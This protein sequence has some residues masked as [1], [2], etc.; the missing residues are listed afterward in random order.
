MARGRGGPTIT[1]VAE[2]AGV[3]RATVS[4]VLN[5]HP[6]VDPGIGARV[7]EAA[8]RLQYR[9]NVTAR[10]LSTGRTRT[11]ALII[12]D[13]GNP[14]FQSLL[15]G[16]SRAAEADGYSVL[17]AEAGSPDTEA[18]LARDARR[19]CDAIMLVSPRMDDLSLEEVLDQAG[20]VV[21][22]NRRPLNPR[23]GVVAI[24]YASGMHQLVEH[25]RELGH[26]D[27]VY[28][29][30]PPRSAA[31]R[32]RLA[33][34][35]SLTGA[36]PSLTLQVLPGGATMSA[37]YEAAE[38]VLAS[39]ATAA[40]AFNDL[41]A[42]GLQSRLNEFGVNVP[43]DISV[44]GFDGIELSRFAVPRLTS[45]GQEQLDAGSVA[46]S[47][48]HQR[49]DDAEGKAGS[50]VTVLEP[51]LQVGDST[52]RVPPSRVPTA[53]GRDGSEDPRAEDLATL[54]FGW[55]REGRDWTLLAGGTL[56]AAAAS[57]SSMPPVHSPRPHLHPVRSLGGRAMTVTNP[58][59]HRHHFGLSLTVPDVNG[60]TYWGG[61]TYVEG[62]GSTLLANHGVQESLEETPD[63]SGH[64]L[65]SRVQWRS[66]DGSD[67]L[68]E[69]RRLG[70][71]LLPGPHGW[72][73]RW[74]SRLR[75]SADPVT[76]TSPANRGR[77]GA[78]YGGLFW[79]LP[80]ADEVRVLVEGGRGEAVAHGSRS[81]FV[82][83]Q[84][85]HGNAWS[86]LLMVQDEEA[87]GRID[88]WFVRASDY[89]GVGTSLAWDAPRRL[90]RGEHLDVVVR[91]A[92]FDH[93][94]ISDEVPDLLAAITAAEGPAAPLP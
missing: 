54:P 12:P 89:L 18:G 69:E 61:R 11:I 92:V 32:E 7:R 59:D 23:T 35:H 55:V 44:A 64:G 4:R 47:L 81:P 40:L 48:L 53:P 34:L 74:R 10:N 3:S 52:G 76:F 14:M 68:H 37:G 72:G 6:S 33:A 2:A 73:L 46:W 17:V 5:Q 16:I 27:L 1:Q 78:G 84:R 19:Q 79:R 93:P 29:A 94:V 67:L 8:Q 31:H 58:S 43:G 49:L 9:P 20:P 15:R 56:L 70:T 50:G 21:V 41:V 60:T 39:Q 77:L 86:S 25:L 51:L 42:F 63:R 36:D 83:V 62:R 45:V 80:G 13:L 26:R 87:Q 28:V 38:A 75:P 71:Y 22:L 57:G 66:H 85:R 65:A 24:D 88:P 91:T 82:I 30:G 90:E